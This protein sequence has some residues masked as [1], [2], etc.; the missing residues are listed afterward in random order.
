MLIVIL[1]KMS[2][3]THKRAKSMWVPMQEFAKKK[4][5]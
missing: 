1:V 3:L 5:D 2:T 4:M